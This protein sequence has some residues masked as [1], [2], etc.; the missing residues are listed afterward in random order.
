M[1]TSI[2]LHGVGKR[3]TKYMDT[4]MLV[5]TALRFRPKTR[6]EKLWAIR[7]V[8]LEV[9]EGEAVGIIGRNGSGKTTVMSMMGGVT[10]PTEGSIRVWG[11]IAPLISVGVGFHPELTGRENVY[12]NGAILGLTRPQIDRRLDEIVE[13]AGIPEFIDTPVKFY[14]SGMLVRLGFSVAV[15]SDPEVL[16]VDEVLAVGDLAFQVKCFERINAMRERGLTLV[17]VSHNMEAIR[18]MCGRILVLNDGIPKFL[19]ET[20]EAIGVYHELLSAAEETQVD[21][22]TGLRFEP[23]VVAIEGVDVLGS[24]GLP[25][26]HIDAGEPIVVQVR[27]RALNAIDD[28]VVRLRLTAADG[29]VVYIDTGHL[30]AVSS[31]HEMTC[32]IRFRAQLPTGTYR[33]FVQLERPDM[34]TALCIGPT[35]S[36][37]V[38]GR[39]VV[40]GH[41]DLEATFLRQQLFDSSARQQV[42]NLREG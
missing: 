40:R 21:Y 5:S 31:G 28:V 33:V 10:A 34:R 6:R 7:G 32:D 2:E 3:F 20:E 23:R 15:H 29:G 18:R 1:G 41:A 27:A 36:F 37:F 19:G 14:S 8:D 39:Q 22:E 16:L 13:F 12:V 42:A 17:T 24:K 25:T 9:S 26:H 38:T 4:P 30:G 35:C 11:R